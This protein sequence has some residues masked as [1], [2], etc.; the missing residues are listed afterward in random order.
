MQSFSAI[1]AK[2]HH[3]AFITFCSTFLRLL[4]QLAPG[5]LE[6]LLS[7]HGNRNAVHL[8]TFT[9][10]FTGQKQVV[11]KMEIPTLMGAVFIWNSNFKSA[12]TAAVLQFFYFILKCLSSGNLFMFGV[13]LTGCSCL[14]K[15]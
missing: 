4:C 2:R 7:E 8:S 14:S 12:D 6:Q 10:K 13:H 5:F 9:S 11:S 3:I 1:I 15:N